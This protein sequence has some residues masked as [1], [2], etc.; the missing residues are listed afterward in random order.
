MTK[1]IVDIDN[2]G[3]VE[4]ILFIKPSLEYENELYSRCRELTQKVIK[5]KILAGELG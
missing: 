1:K 2:L 5:K 4:L 3:K